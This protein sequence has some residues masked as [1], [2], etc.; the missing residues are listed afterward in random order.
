M[1]P[2]PDSSIPQK[3]IGSPN[4]CPAVLLEKG[5]ARGKRMSGARGQKIY[6]HCPQDAR[7]CVQR[8]KDFCEA[9]R[10]NCFSFSLFLVGEKNRERIKAIKNPGLQGRGELGPELSSVEWAQRI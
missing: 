7:A 6:W 9:M 5:G 10:T 8:E 4:F 3:Q 2:E 1:E